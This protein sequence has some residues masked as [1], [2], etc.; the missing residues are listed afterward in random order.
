MKLKIYNRHNFHKHTFCV[1]KEVEFEEITNLIPNYSSESG[2]IY[3]F[4]SQGLYRFSNHWGRVANCRWKLES[5]LTESFKRDGK[6]IGYANWSDFYPNNEKENLFYIVVDFDL[7][8]IDFQHCN[9]PQYD[10]KSICRNASDTAKRIKI[11]KEVLLEEKW[12][13]YLKFDSIDVLRKIII[14]E[15]VYTNATFLSIRQKFL[16]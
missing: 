2:S 11:C 12:A 9:N 3:Y 4:T 6:K 1:F 15:L 7:K 10:E 8:M 16:K 14:Q 5:I 13:A